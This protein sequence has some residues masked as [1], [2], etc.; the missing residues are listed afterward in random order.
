[1]QRGLMVYVWQDNKKCPGP[2]DYIKEQEVAV[3]MLS[4]F[5]RTSMTKFNKE[6][7]SNPFPPKNVD[8][9]GPG[10]YVFLSEFGEC[11]TRNVGSQHSYEGRVVK[12]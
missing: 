12:S 10:N 9:P 11:A 2:G 4:Q 8:M 3:K 7:R 1:M 6:Q 5:H